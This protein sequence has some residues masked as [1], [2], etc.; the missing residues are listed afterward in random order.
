MP[1]LAEALSQPQQPSAQAQGDPLAA[2]SPQ[3]KQK[4]LQ[5]YQMQQAAQ[6]FPSR[7]SQSLD[8]SSHVPPPQP[9]MPQRQQ[10]P[11]P[12]APGTSGDNYD[13]DWYA[14]AASRD[15]A[16]ANR[17]MALRDERRQRLANALQAIGVQ[18][19]G[20]APSLGQAVNGAPI[21]NPSPSITPNPMIGVRG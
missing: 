21:N 12:S 4:L 16:W 7:L 10:F 2:L 1:S 19:R 6:Q 5:M 17:L 13:A 18:Q 9:Q 20:T 8:L 15:P 11:M 14:K 3:E